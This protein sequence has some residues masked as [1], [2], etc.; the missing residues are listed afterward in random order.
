VPSFPEH[1][2]RTVAFLGYDIPQVHRT[3]D[4][5]AAYLGGRHRVVGHNL[6]MARAIEDLFGRAG[7]VV[8]TCHLLQDAGILTRQQRSPGVEL[9][10]KVAPSDRLT[11]ETTQPALTDTPPGAPLSDPSSAQAGQLRLALPGA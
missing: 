3:I 4:A 10:S 11:R 9:P 6:K 7:L 2:R 8:F 1:H 5:A